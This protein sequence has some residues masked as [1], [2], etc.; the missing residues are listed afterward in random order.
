MGIFTRTSADPVEVPRASKAYNA[1]RPLT[2]AAQRVQLDD[3]AEIERF[4]A[5]RSGDVWQTTCWEYYDAIGEIK[6]SGGLVG[7]IMS[8]VRLFPAGVTSDDTI[9]SAL[10]EIDDLAPGVEEA[11]RRALYSLNTANGGIPGLLRDVAINLFVAGE[12][13]LVRTPERLGSGE[14]ERWQIKSVDE[15]VP[16]DGR[17]AKWAIRERRN[18]GRNELI[19]LPPRS[20]A[21]RIWR[22]H[23]RFSAEADSSMRGLIEMM[24]ELML[25]NRSMRATTR[26][27]LNAGMLF[28]PDELAVSAS[29]DGLARPEVDAADITEIADDGGDDFEEELIDAMTTPI[30]DESSA[31]AV[32]P[33]LVRGPSEFADRI[34]LIKFERS[35][36]VQMVQRAERV[37]DRILAGL[38]IPK[39]VVNGLSGVKYSN[40]VQI[41]ES[42]Y[43]GHIEPL[44]LLIC[45][46]LTVGFL[47]PVLK[48]QGFTDSDISRVV[49]WYDPSAVTTKPDRASAATQ[50][51]QLHELSGAAWRRANGFSDADKPDPIETAQRVA[52]QRGALSEPITEALWQ[53]LI[54]QLM[55]QVR[56]QT[57]AQNPELSDTA[58]TLINGAPA[59]SSEPAATPTDSAGAPDPAAAISDE[60]APGSPAPSAGPPPGLVE[61]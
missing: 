35:F 40:A 42:L 34:K 17:G 32:V 38:D 4:K 57:L 10:D 25:L 19:E 23:P 7:S 6:Y 44:A 41:E 54:P 50:G 51:Y 48:A 31:S 58:Q 2:A 22:M 21:V 52:V 9:P 39:D 3:K 46:A 8:R 29:V 5:R 30:A 53:L 13:Y 55:A 26:S 12:C 56:Q 61:P 15:L 11:A 28:V 36:D 49:L 16:L 1:P 60:A 59:G 20:V 33:L 14:P 43:R 18:A 27:R 24:D 37:L 47:R 45:D